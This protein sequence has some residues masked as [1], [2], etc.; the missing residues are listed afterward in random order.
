MS[1]ILVSVWMI[2]Y[3]HEEYISQALDSILMQKTIYD[4]EVII[5]EDSSTDNTR[6][7]V[8]EYERKYPAIIKPIYHKKNIGA[9]RNAFEYC[10]PKIKGKY[11][12]CLEGDDYWTDINKIQKQVDFLEKYSEYGMVHSDA[13]YLYQKDNLLIKNYNKKNKILIPIGNIFHNLILPD[14]SMLIKTATST[15]RKD[16]IDKY[17]DY[18]T[19]LKNK[20]E[21][22]DLALYLEIAYN[23]KIHY[24]DDSTAVYRLQ[25]ESASRTSS[26]LKKYEFHKSVFNIYDYY[27]NKYSIN[28]DIKKQVAIRF[29]KCMIIDAY[30]IKDKSLSKKSYKYLK[31]NGIVLNKK[32]ML[33]YLGTMNKFF[34]YIIEL[35]K[36]YFR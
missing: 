24:M 36:R 10:L 18:K 26:A 11:I 7:L 9:I 33:Y 19:A 2:T 21:L 8:Q 28:K 16:V 4:I 29:S 34:R 20:W 25:E 30:N 31:S 23:S 5:G 1:D 12:A 32:E 6:K 22:T 3:N 27:L 13:D 35:F 17:F 15:I 14:S